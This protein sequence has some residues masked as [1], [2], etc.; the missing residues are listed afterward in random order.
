MR[1]RKGKRERKKRRKGETARLE[2][3]PLSRCL[4]T[5][6]LLSK[7]FGLTSEPIRSAFH[8]DAGKT[9]TDKLAPRQNFMSWHSPSKFWQN[10]TNR[11]IFYMTPRKSQP[12]RKTRTI[13]E[14]KP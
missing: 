14:Q 11:P 9:S 2:D 4:R 13:W 7:A 10:A 12:E 8:D 6:G 3:S 1:Q 5:R